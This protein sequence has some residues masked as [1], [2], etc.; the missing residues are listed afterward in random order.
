MKG[1]YGSRPSTT[2]PET[3]VPG[4]Q[5]RC[6]AAIEGGHSARTRRE[7]RGTRLPARRWKAKAGKTDGSGRARGRGSSQRAGRAGGAQ[8]QEEEEEEVVCRARTSTLGAG[9]ESGRG[10]EITG[11]NEGSRNMR[12]WSCK[13][14]SLGLRPFADVWAAANAAQQCRQ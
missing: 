10:G 9:R 1:A 12:T 2:R 3:A 11:G 13:G 6:R 14:S 8:Q 7:S 5:R 4:S